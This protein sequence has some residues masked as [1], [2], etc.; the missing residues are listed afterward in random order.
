MAQHG[1][2]QGGGSTN[3]LIAPC[4]NAEGGIAPPSRVVF[5]QW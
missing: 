3:L 4:G 2:N 1:V 5:A